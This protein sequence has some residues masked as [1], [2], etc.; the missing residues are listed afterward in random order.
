MT[1]TASRRVSRG[2]TAGSV[3]AAG[4]YFLFGGVYTR[5]DIRGLAAESAERAEALVSLQLEL[6][7]IRALGDSLESDP[8]TIER[9]ARE[10]YSFLRPG[11]LLFRFVPATPEAGPQGSSEE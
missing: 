4:Y 8:R 10:R 6:A 11:E 5:S 2:I 9:V 3:L 7:S 1:E